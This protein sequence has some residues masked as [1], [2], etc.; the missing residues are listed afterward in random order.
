MIDDAQET[1]LS[2]RPIIV[3]SV[4]LGVMMLAALGLIGD[5]WTEA[6]AENRAHLYNAMAAVFFSFQA[7][8]TVLA[9]AYALFRTARRMI[10]VINLYG[11]AVFAVA[12]VMATTHFVRFLKSGA[13]GIV[14]SF[15]PPGL[16]LLALAQVLVFGLILIVSLVI[17]LR[18]LFRRW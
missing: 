14:D 11:I 5:L 16:E 3:A 8:V 13:P 17:G 12:V 15:V 7:N 6:S 9:I 2:L 1:E 4:A 18:R 10:L